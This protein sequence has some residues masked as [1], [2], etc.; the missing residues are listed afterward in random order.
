MNVIEKKTF[1]LKTHDGLFDPQEKRFAPMNGASD[2][3]L[4]LRQRRVALMCLKDLFHLFLCVVVVLV[5][6]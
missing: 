4:V 1:R 6:G 2:R 3:G 5:V